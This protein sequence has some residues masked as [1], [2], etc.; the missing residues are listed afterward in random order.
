MFNSYVPKGPSTNK[1][2][3][4]SFDIYKSLD[5]RGSTYCKS[6]LS[7]YP[8]LYYP[9]VRRSLHEASLQLIKGEPY[10][11]GSMEGG[12]WGTHD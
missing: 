3:T 11:R 10:G 7:N 9:T 4:L 5:P 6:W 2:R 12:S 8:P 1:M